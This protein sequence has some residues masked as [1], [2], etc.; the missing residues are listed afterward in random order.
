MLNSSF[1]VSIYIYMEEGKCKFECLIEDF[2]VKIFFMM[3]QN[4]KAVV[5][6]RCISKSWHR[7]VNSYCHPRLTCNGN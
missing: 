5:R 7:L 3:A 6:L 1:G 4:M 2:M